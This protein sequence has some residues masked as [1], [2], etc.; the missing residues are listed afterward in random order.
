MREVPPLLCFLGSSMCFPADRNLDRLRLAE[1][2]IVGLTRPC[3]LDFSFR[4]VSSGFG[5][6]GN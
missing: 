2:T 5:V 3:L 6:L 1:F 4:G